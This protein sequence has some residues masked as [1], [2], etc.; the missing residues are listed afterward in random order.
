[1][2][3]AVI[4]ALIGLV[5]EVD[6]SHS[7]PVEILIIAVPRPGWSPQWTLHLFQEALSL[8]PQW[9]ATQPGCQSWLLSCPD[10]MCVGGRRSWSGLTTSTPTGHPGR[11][12]FNSTFSKGPLSLPPSSS[13][14]PPFLLYCLCLCMC[15]PVG[16]NYLSQ[17]LYS[18][19]LETGSLIKLT[20]SAKPTCPKKPSCL[21]LPM[22]WVSLSCPA[23]PV[24]A[25]DQNLG[26][27]TVHR[28][29]R[30][31]S[32]PFFLCPSHPLFLLSCLPPFLFLPS[33]L[34]ICLPF[35]Q[36]FILI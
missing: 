3:G 13:L 24:G 19:F 11:K 23:F 12:D 22:S 20:D 21:C 17:L 29:S 10:E 25:G 26:F 34:Y 9:S 27:Q 2:L 28:L 36:I 7:A 4:S 8:S 33:F 14:P 18:C 32:S 15:V 16:V 5:D 35:N 6:R 1:M 31:P 30:F